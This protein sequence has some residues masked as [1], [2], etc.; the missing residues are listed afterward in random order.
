M[1][2]NQREKMQLELLLLQTR[3]NSVKELQ[4]VRRRQESKL[5]PAT[6][7]HE[8]EDRL[9]SWMNETEH[10]LSGLQDAEDEKKLQDNTEPHLDVSNISTGFMPSFLPS[11][12][13]VEINKVL[14]SIADTELLLNAPE[15]SSGEYENFNVQ[16]ELLTDIKDSLDKLGE[17]I[18]AIHEKQPDVILEASGPEAIQ[19]GDSLTQVNA[20]WDRINRL[21]SD[22]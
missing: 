10:R 17:Q 20:E 15:L 11:D 7:Q 14:L 6:A 22:R 16:E 4:M 12:Y 8:Q 13:L 19:I 5:S 3:Y 1:D 21:Y 18:A 9:F 2:D